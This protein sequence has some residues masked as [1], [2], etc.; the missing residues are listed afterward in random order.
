MKNGNQ[1]VD[2]AHPIDSRLDT[3]YRSGHQVAWLAVASVPV[4][5]FAKFL[6]TSSVFEECLRSGLQKSAE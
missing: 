4:T 6:T 2:Y 1:K 3:D 5:R